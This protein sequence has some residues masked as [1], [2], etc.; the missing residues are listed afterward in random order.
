M[1]RLDRVMYKYKSL[2]S[3]SQ[4]LT[5][6][7]FSGELLRVYL[8]RMNSLRTNVFCVLKRAR[9]IHSTSLNKVVN[10][11]LT[12]RKRIYKIMRVRDIENLFKKHNL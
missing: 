7:K 10:F 9:K 3:K 6:L 2:G 5:N 8:R 4:E 12:E 11:T 1:K